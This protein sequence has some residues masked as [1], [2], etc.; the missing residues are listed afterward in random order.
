MVW[1]QIIKSLNNIQ[2]I[3][4]GN[5]AIED[6]LQKFILGLVT[7]ATENIGWASKPKEDNLTTRLRSLL[8]AT[9]GGAGHDPTIAEAKKLFAAYTSGK[10]DA[11]HPS[12]RMPV[13]GI[14][15]KSGGSTEYEAVKKDYIS[16]TSVDGKEI[17]LQAMGYVQTTDLVNDFMDFQLSDKVAVQDAHSGAISLAANAKAR[18]ALWTY[19]T[20]HWD[21]IEAKLSANSV[22][23]ARFVKSVLSKYSTLEMEKEITKFFEGKDTKG[24]D[25]GL[26]EV[27]DTIKGNARYKERDEKLL[28]DWLQAHDYA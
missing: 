24:Y 12:L 2:S 9:A 10:S 28:L 11:I 17:G 4:A 6:G 19:I 27:S 5:K 15:V 18:D 14:V 8:I 25:R 20:T 3:F 23:I 16:S 13:F 26:V 22:V 1:A 21:T 7:P